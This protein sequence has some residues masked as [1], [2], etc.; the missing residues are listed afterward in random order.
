MAFRRK[1]DRTEADRGGRLHQDPE[2][3]PHV[4]GVVKPK[5][6]GMGNQNANE[7]MKALEDDE[8]GKMM[9]KAPKGK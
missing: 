4:H 1:E 3:R 7:M 6:G 2:G 5:S 9:P 8:M